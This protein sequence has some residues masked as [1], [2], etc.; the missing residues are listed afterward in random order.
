MTF[1]LLIKNNSSVLLNEGN[2]AVKFEGSS[3]DGTEVIK[4]TQFSHLKLL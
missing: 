1:D 2:H 4:Q 3:S